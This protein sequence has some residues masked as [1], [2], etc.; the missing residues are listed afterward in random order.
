V[1]LPGRLAAGVFSI[2][3]SLGS[4]D[5]GRYASLITWG[6]AAGR[7]TVKGP[8]GAYAWT[9]GDFMGFV[10]STTGD[11]LLAS[12]GNAVGFVTAGGYGVVHVVGDY[13]GTIDAVEDALAVTLGK[14]DGYVTSGAD[15]YILGQD[16]V[17][18]RVTADR[19]A[20][21]HAVGDV[22]GAL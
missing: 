9:Y 1:D 5:A 8:A 3:Y 12:Y 19:D 4:I 17:N 10:E 15:A 7:M 14:F 6:D 16:D 20:Y 2:D 13:F 22:R 18:A 11:A 21:V